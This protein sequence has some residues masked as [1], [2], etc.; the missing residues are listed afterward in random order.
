MRARCIDFVRDEKHCY[1]TVVLEPS[2]WNKLWGART[3]AIDM[4]CMDY[5]SDNSPG[6]RTIGTG[7]RLNDLDHR[8][9]IRDALDQREVGEVRRPT[10]GG[11]EPV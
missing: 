8:H 4:V 9:V 5:K 7:R 2:W 6:W 11:T 1:A 10:A 3:V